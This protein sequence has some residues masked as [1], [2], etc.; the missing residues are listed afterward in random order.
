M[1]LWTFFSQKRHLLVVELTHFWIVEQSQVERS[2]CFQHLRSSTNL[3]GCIRWP[4]SSGFASRITKFRIPTSSFLKEWSFRSPEPVSWRETSSSRIRK[5]SMRTISLR[6]RRAR[7]VRTH[8]WRSVKGRGTALENDLECF[9]WRAASSDW[10]LTSGWWLAKKRSKNWC[11][12]PSQC[13]KSR[14]VEY[15]SQIRKEKSK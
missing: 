3:S 1:K 15:G 11:R 9:K 4:W 2:T 12:T 7:E 13:L 10:Y 8:F 5:S 14:K 6:K